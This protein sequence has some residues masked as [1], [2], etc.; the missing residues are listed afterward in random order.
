MIKNI[1]I[2]IRMCRVGIARSLNKIFLKK[3]KRKKKK[4]KL[5][6]GLI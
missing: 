3:E 5:L 1:F 4:K 2:L 6:L